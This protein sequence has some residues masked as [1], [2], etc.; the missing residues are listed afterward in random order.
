MIE[1]HSQTKMIELHSQTKMIEFSPDYGLIPL[2]FWKHVDYQDVPFKVFD[3][4]R[5]KVSNKVK[6]D[7][8]LNIQEKI[9]KNVVENFENYT[10]RK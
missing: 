2:I 1:L 9:L 8:Q 4:F 7:I 6:V 10:K 5:Y 3:G